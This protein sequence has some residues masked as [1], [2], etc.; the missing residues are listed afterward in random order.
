VS[1][2]VT[3]FFFLSKK[4]KERERDLWFSG[5]FILRSEIFYVV[6]KN[7]NLVFRIPG[8]WPRKY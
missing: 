7:I 4:I 5:I 2:R 1:S 3:C 6:K 8:F